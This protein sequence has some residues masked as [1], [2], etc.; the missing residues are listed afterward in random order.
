MTF[1]NMTLLSSRALEC[2]LKSLCLASRLGRVGV[3]DYTGGFYVSVLD[4]SS[5]FVP[6]P[7]T[8]LHG[9]T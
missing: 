6:S 3:K 4:K 5:I 7:G 1:H 2:F 8:Q 9:F